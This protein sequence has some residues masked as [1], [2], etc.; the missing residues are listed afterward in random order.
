[1][2]DSSRKYPLAKPPGHKPPVPRW[3]LEF[4]SPSPLYTAYIGVQIHRQ[5]ADSDTERAF[6]SAIEAVQAWIKSASSPERRIETFVHLE[7]DDIPGAIVWVVYWK[8]S[9]DYES[10]MK[11]LDL[12]TIYKSVHNTS[13]GLWSE[14]FTTPV[15]RLETNYSGTDYLPGLARL[16]GSSTS[17]HTRTAYWGAARDRIPDSGHDAFE[18]L[19]REEEAP[20]DPV[21]L[22]KRISGTNSFDNIVHIRSGQFWGNC[23]NTEAEAYE[24]KL[25]P[26]LREGLRYVWENRQ[27]SGAMGLRFLRNKHINIAGP[28]TE[29]EAKETCAAG[30]FRN[31]EDLERW[32]KR[33]PSHLAIFNGALRHAKEF[34]PER[35]FRTWHEVSILKKGEI[36]FEYVNCFPETGVL[37]FMKLEGE[38]L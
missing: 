18:R 12:N 10:S 27:D 38:D 32:A 28:D 26:A 24:T 29:H 36:K 22:G 23:S 20:L 5:N 35:K 14:T 13:I 16:P 2:S 9:T 19:Q 6:N 30:F 34:G 8:N 3:T 37:R 21:T 1:M 31:L 11:T 17:E 25:E 33:H 7:G 15:S 4:E